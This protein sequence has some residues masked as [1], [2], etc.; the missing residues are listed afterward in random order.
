MAMHY[1]YGWPMGHLV[2]RLGLPTKIV[3]N[4]IRDDEAGVFVGTSDDVFGLV[5]E[6]ETLEE[7][8]REARSLIPDLIGATSIRT[9]DGVVDLRYRDSLCHA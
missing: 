4:V 3:I 8:S 6:A 1:R 5:V 2:A 9:R 7:L